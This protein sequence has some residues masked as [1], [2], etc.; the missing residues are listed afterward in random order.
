MSSNTPGTRSRRRVEWVGVGKYHGRELFS[1]LVSLVFSLVT[2][3]V[4]AHPRAPYTPTTRLES[5]F[6]WWDWSN[7]CALMDC[8]D[9]KSAREPSPH[10]LQ[11]FVRCAWQN[12]GTTLADL[13]AL[14]PAHTW[15]C[16]A[17]GTNLRRANDTHSSPCRILA[18]RPESTSPVPEA[19]VAL[20]VGVFLDL[21]CW[22]PC[23]A[24]PDPWTWNWPAFVF[25]A[26][27]R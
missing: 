20:F 23:A 14:W 22:C 17:Q 5:G 7:G 25:C 10:P 18:L 16:L 12:H 8:C 11:P 24:P 21:D 4:T 6:Q 1:F 15:C 27:C 19:P 2:H 3:R 13:K 9:C 26:S